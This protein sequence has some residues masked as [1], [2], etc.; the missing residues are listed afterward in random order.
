MHALDRAGQG[1]ELA[2]GG[3]HRLGDAVQPEL[4]LGDDAERA[5]GADHQVGEV[6]AGGG[7]AHP[8]AGLDQPAVRQRHLQAEHV[9]ADGAVADGGGAAGA[10]RAH[11]ADGALAAGIDREEQALVA[12]VLVELLPGHAG[13]DAAVHVGGVDLRGRG[14][15]ARGRG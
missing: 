13:L 10:R 5:L 1:G 3:A 2:D 4:D 14:S 6:V 9:L 7:F 11:A 15:C 12:Q 8:A